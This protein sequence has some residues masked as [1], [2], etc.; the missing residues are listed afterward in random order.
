MVA[1]QL[2]KSYYKHSPVFVF[3]F[4]KQVSFIIEK[5]SSVCERYGLIF[6]FRIPE[7]PISLDYC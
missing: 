1:E 7:K 4:S 6:H 2:I 5:C 3:E